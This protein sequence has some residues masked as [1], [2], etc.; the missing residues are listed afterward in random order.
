MRPA[1]RFAVAVA[2]SILTILLLWCGGPG[3]VG[4]S[5][6]PLPAEHYFP[7]DVS[8]A[9][10]LKQFE[11]AFEHYWTRRGFPETDMAIE[12]ILRSIA[13]WDEWRETLSEA[14]IR[15]RITAFREAFF[16]LM[17]PESWL[18]FGQWEPE[19]EGGP[20]ETALLLFLQEGAAVRLAVAPFLDLMLP[21]KRTVV[22]EYRG[23]EILQYISE[24]E[25]D[26]WTMARMGGWVCISMRNR[27]SNALPRIIDQHL[28]ARDGEAETPPPFFG[29]PEGD[30]PE[31]ALRARLVTEPLWKHVIDLEEQRLERDPEQGENENRT[32]RWQ[33]RLRNI[34]QVDMI[35]ATDA[36]LDLNFVF[37]GPRIDRMEAVLKGEAEGGGSPPLTTDLTPEPGLP[38]SAAQIDFSYPMAARG[39]RYVGLDW[40]DFLDEMDDLDSLAPGLERRLEG[41]MY[42]DRGPLEARIGAAITRTGGAPFL[43]ITVWRDHPPILYTPHAPADAWTARALARHR[44]EGDLMYSV[45]KGRQ[46]A[47]AE[48]AM[49]RAERELANSLWQSP[50]RPPEIF[51]VFNWD[52]VLRW[53][54]DVPLLLARRS[55]TFESI[56]HFAQGMKLATGSLA[57][58][59]DV[60]DGVATLRFRTL[61]EPEIES[62]SAP[63][64]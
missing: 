47:P 3:V 40:D 61:P 25:R 12:Q 6:A 33:R 52:E 14:A 41:A 23:V 60:Q 42:E 53:M 34:S 39:L 20:P 17:G 11:P 26:D 62:A 45:L 55:D 7:D 51:L 21:E 32:E 19:E 35:Q 30:G 37:R 13:P 31:P 24:H 44:G 63:A 4:P 18:V 9:I 29:E 57:A 28:A 49:I 1:E 58:R 27:N 64:S 36:F 56:Q 5:Y 8:G 48:A 10:R 16:H 15:R 38:L 46:E 22:S 54:D 2:G 59:F 43:G 50:S